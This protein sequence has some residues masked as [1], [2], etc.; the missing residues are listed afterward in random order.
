MTRPSSSLRNL[1]FD[2]PLVTDMAGTIV[3]LGEEIGIGGEGR[4]FA[5]QGKAHLAAKLY[6]K[7]A[8]PE[9]S[10][11]KL[12]AMVEIGADQLAPIYAWPHDLLLDSRNRAVRGVLMPRITDARE[13]HELYGTTNRARHYPQAQ[14]G[15]L[16]L[17]AR[18]TA[19]AFSAMHGRGVIVGDVN[20]GNLLVDQE[21]RVRFIDC[22]SFQIQMRNRT[23]RCPV[24]TPHFTPPELQ[25][26]KLS[27]VSRTKDHDRFGMAILIFHLLFVGRHPFAGR[28]NGPGDMTIEK[29]IAERRFAF[30]K[31][32]EETLVNPPPASLEL[33]DLP[34]TLGVL[35]ERAFR[36]LE[37][38][39]RPTPEQW[40]AEL[41]NLLRLRQECEIDSAHVYYNSL[42][43]CPWC[44]IEDAGGPSFFL[45]AVA[46]MGGGSSSEARLATLD[47]QVN[48]IR[49]IHFPELPI[50]LLKLP[51][52]PPVKETGKKT[53]MAQADTLSIGW[54]L[55]AVAC[56]AGIFYWPAVAGGALGSLGTML[57]LLLGPSGKKRRMKLDKF[58]QTLNE[59]LQRVATAAHQIEA[60]HNGRKAEYDNYAAVL[61][62]GRKRYEADTE[63]I[64]TILKEVR[65]EQKEEFLQ[66]FS[67]RDYRRKIPGLEP[68][69]V[70][71]LESY[72]VETAAELDKHLLAGI[73]NIDQELI[74]EL[75]SWRAKMEEKFQFKTDDGITERELHA[76]RQ[77]AT[78]LFKISQARKLISGA[79]RLRAM[80]HAGKG[81]LD[82]DMAVFKRLANQWRE[83]AR[84]RQD[85]QAGRTKLE[86]FLNGSTSILLGL[87][88]ATPAVCALFWF[89]FK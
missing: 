66:G 73:P 43:T 74:M 2:K 61:G 23:F 6:H 26:L 32:Q 89:F 46:G 30:S 84:K 81:M 33:K 64:Q 36:K 65:E 41:E 72:N 48:R 8:L 10:A 85:S 54:A 31:H 80:V 45:V 13:L 58:D 57:G 68:V 29:A 14:W 11:M 88:I 3:P 24:G 49:D 28:Y 78:R 87:G 47:A 21:M 59:G 63:N 60:A 25:S 37:G 5:V 19:A 16:V 82:K 70:V 34:P 53:K 83:I 75:L 4:V 52:L 40:A 39:E 20:Q 17:A 77:E 69:L 71:T 67:L 35:F 50:R 42:M 18:N 44:R 38:E 22:D 27:E 56:V 9:D 62:V 79:K 55:S 12:R 86:R 1:P 15:H 76:N 7:G 51:A